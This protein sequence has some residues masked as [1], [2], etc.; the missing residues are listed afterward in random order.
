MRAKIR[1]YVDAPLGEGQV[2]GFS[3]AEVSRL[4]G[5]DQVVPVT[6]GPRIL[7]VETAVVLWPATLG[8]WW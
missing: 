5:M 3:D 7:R 6:H 1:L 8:D 4:R 2:V